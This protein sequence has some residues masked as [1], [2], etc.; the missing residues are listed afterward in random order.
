MVRIALIVCVLFGAA[1]P[2]AAS[3]RIPIRVGMG[4]QQAAMFDQPAYQRLKIKRVRYFIRWNAMRDPQRLAD[5]TAYVRR[6]R[7]AGTQVLLHLSTDDFTPRK[8]HLPTTAEYHRELRTLVPYFRRLGVREFGA[9][10]EVNNATQP[11][12]KSPTRA[13]A[14]FRDMYRVVKGGCASCTVVALDVLDQSGVERY[15]KRFYGALSPTFR[16]RASVVGLH[17]YGD[18]NRLRSTYTRSM[19]RTVKRSN[20]RATFWLTETGGLVKLG[21]SF[22]FSPARAKS[23][24]GQMFRLAN[25]NRRSGITR[26][27]IYS[28]TGAQRTERFDAGLTEP[29]GDVR[30]GYTYV[31]THISDYLR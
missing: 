12:Y 15:I 19:I 31:R 16:R 1:L 30:P 26:L 4:D 5:A 6:A 24:L 7:A 22:P 13:A 23:R 28:W 3:A 21:P 14:Y 29:N 9:W 18:V 17:N 27:Y 11:T 8:A 2:A 25:A 10:N 20:P